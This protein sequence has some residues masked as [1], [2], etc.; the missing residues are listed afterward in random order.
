MDG[1]PEKV[2]L[3]TAVQIDVMIRQ[4]MKASKLKHAAKMRPNGNAYRPRKE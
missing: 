3:T 2:G 1:G 4:G